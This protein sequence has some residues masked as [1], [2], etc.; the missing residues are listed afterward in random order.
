[1]NDDFNTPILIAHLFE[2]VRVINSVKDNK[3]TLTE[4]DLQL[5]RGLMNS[6][7]FD[8]LG[9]AGDS[10]EG[11]TGLVDGL[12]D[13]ILDIRARARENKDWDTSDLIRDNLNRLKI[14]VK[15]TKDGSEWSID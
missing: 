14:Q 7:V 6:Y 5:L 10:E 11:Q 13:T 3:E 8:I 4:K 12:M 2:G 15:D 1:M 9:L